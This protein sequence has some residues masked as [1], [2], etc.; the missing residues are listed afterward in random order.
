MTNIMVES[1]EKELKERCT[2]ELAKLRSEGRTITHGEFEA[3]VAELKQ[4]EDH[5]IGQAEKTLQAV[6][7]MRDEW[8]EEIKQENCKH[9][10]KI[11]KADYDAPQCKQC[12]KVFSSWYC[13][14]SPDHNCHYYSHKVK[15]GFAITL[16]SG[17]EFKIEHK[18]TLQ[19]HENEEEDWCIFCGQP[20]ERK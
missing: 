14:N 2:N 20:E 12:Q 5:P 18:Y 7:K 4:N 15:G 11:G 9:D 3:H 8:S 19:D 10:G 16:V 13:P 1:L 6:T 17:K